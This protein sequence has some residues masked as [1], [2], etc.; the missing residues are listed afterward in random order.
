MIN[1]IVC[2]GGRLFPKFLSFYFTAA[3]RFSKTHYY[4]I[5]I[6]SYNNTNRQFINCPYNLVGCG[7]L[8][9]PSNTDEPTTADET[10]TVNETATADESVSSTTVDPQ[11]ATIADLNPILYRSYYYDKETDW[12]YLTSR[13]YSPELCRFINSDNYALPTATPTEL[14]DKNLFAYC[15]NNP[16]TRVD[17]EGTFWNFVIGAVVGAA[18]SAASAAISGGDAKSIAL[19]AV[20]GAIGG[21]IGASGLGMVGQI[22]AGAILS[23]G[24]N[25]ANQTL[26]EGKSLKQLTKED[27]GNV[28]IDA[29]IGGVTAAVS[30]KI[31][32]S[33]SKEATKTIN[34]GMYRYLK[35]EQRLIRGDRYYKGSMKRGLETMNSGFKRLNTVRG[36]SSAIGSSLS[37][38][39][40]TVKNTFRRRFKR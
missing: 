11:I 21:I 38:F 32:L 7:V 29:T 40:T 12:Y 20:T 5:K 35:G 15:D 19:S 2:Y 24:S 3:H 23:G 27:W 30:Y 17:D 13:F 37:G 34:D 36:K 28:L 33:S 26:V 10:T 9:V 18:I 31:T 1:F 6:Q 39:F 14:T 4:I 22:A 25:L 16:V 8:D